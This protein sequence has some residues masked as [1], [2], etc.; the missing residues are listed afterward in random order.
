MQRLSSIKFRRP[1]IPGAIANQCLIVRLA[2]ADA[3]RGHAFIVNAYL[4]SRFDIVIENHF[5]AAGDKRPANLDRRQPIRMKVS[6]KLIVKVHHEI[7]READYQALV[8][9]RT[10]DVWAPKLD[11]TE[12][13]NYVVAEFVDSIRQKRKPLTDGEAGL[14]VVRILE[15]AQQSIKEEGNFKLLGSNVSTSVA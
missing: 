8:S 6:N 2:I 10:G 11:A 15:A 14:R 1:D 13:L 5:A 7:N 3:V 4:F 9:Y 12:A